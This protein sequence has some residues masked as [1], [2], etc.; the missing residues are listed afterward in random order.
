MKDSLGKE[1]VQ[2][3]QEF[4]DALQTGATITEQFTC[5]KVVLDLEPGS[6]GPEKV[7]ETRKALGVSQALFAQFLGVSAKTVRAWEQGKNTPSDM[8]RRFMDEI[9]QDPAHWR[10]RLRDSAVVKQAATSS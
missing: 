3:L 2:G 6:Y 5:R 7:K 8:A 9:R 4:A 10:K 1:I